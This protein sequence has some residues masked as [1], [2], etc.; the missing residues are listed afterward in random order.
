MNITLTMNAMALLEMF[1]FPHMKLE[2][3]MK[4][5][6]GL[7]L[8]DAARETAAKEAFSELKAKGLVREGRGFAIVPMGPDVEL[9]GDESAEEFEAAMRPR[10]A[11]TPGWVVTEKAIQALAE[12]V[13]PDNREKAIRVM[14]TFIADRD[15]EGRTH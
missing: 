8:K 1:A 10:L 15:T 6:F 14:R 3:T 11:E 13:G 7:E 4:D 12:T 9:T 5:Q 2:P